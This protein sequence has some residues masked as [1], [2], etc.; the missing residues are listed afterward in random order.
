MRDRAAMAIE[1]PRPVVVVV[2]IAMVGGIIWLTNRD[3]PSSANRTNEAPPHVVDYKTV[4]Q[5]LIPNGGWS[6]VVVID[7]STRMKAISGR[8]GNS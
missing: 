2:M 3:Q 4:E 6:R 1:V 5:R 7:P 8:W